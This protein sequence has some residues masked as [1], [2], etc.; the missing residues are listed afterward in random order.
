MSDIV[1]IAP[2]VLGNATAVLTETAARPVAPPAPLPTTLQNLPQALLRLPPNAVIQGTIL[3]STPDG[4]AQLRTPQGTLTVNLQNPPPAGTQVSVQLQG[5]PANGANATLTVQPQATPAPA[6]GSAP[7]PPAVLAG[8]QTVTATATSTVAPNAPA[9]PAQVPDTLRPALAGGNQPVLADGARVGLRIAAV[10]AQP[11]QAPATPPGTL[12]AQVGTTPGGSAT[13]LTGLGTLRLDGGT[14]LQPGTRLAVEVT[15][16]APRSA[17]LAATPN[18]LGLSR[19]WPAL[20]DALQAAAALG[21]ATA[22][23]AQAA[24]PRPGPGLGTDMLFLM[25]ALRLGDPKAFLGD[26]SMRALQSASAELAARIG[27]DFAA[28][29]RLAAAGN[30]GEWRTWLLPV[31]DGETLRQLRLFTRNQK[32]K[33]A[34]PGEDADAM[35]FI[36]ELELS[37]LGLMQIDG[38]THEGRFDL[39]VRS[40]AP[41]P[42]HVREGIRSIYTA[43]RGEDGTRGE[44]GFQDG[45]PF[46]VSPGE[47]VDAGHLGLSV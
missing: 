23:A 2:Q 3:S 47:A 42:K 45:K 13:L 29:A 35:R 11:G 36:V 27:D 7:A 12:P 31:L 41:L 17:P 37:N 14:A 39:M 10:G 1:K 34:K 38:F 33:N 44:L 28:M 22:N 15:S 25:A 20:R 9:L 8:S 18:P 21:P 16:A 30:E 19:D 6:Q 40:K 43:F 5:A 32:R 24:V 26:T 4:T 46:P